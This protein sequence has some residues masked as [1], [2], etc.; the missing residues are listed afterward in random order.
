MRK[1]KK[2]N[3]KPSAWWAV[4]FTLMLTAFTGYVL[5][6]AFVIPQT[7]EVVAG[8]DSETTAAASASDERTDTDSNEVVITDTTYDDG[9]ISI[10]IITYR[11][12]DT[13]VYVA[14]ITLTSADD[15][16]TAFANNTYGKN[17]TEN[18]SV[19]AA[20]NN[21]I[22]AINGDYY[23]ARS[24]YVI[25]NGTLYRA[26]SSDSM[27]E[28]LVIY[29]DGTMQIITEGD[30]TAAQL[31]ADGAV[32]VF[33]FGPGLVEN[34]KISVT[35]S[36]EVD[37]AMT[38]NPR[39]AIGMI[40]GLHYVMV[41]ADG[42]TSES[43]GLSLY[44]LAEFMQSELGVTLAYNLDG[45]GSSTMYFNG[46]VINNPTTNGTTIQERSVSDIVYIQ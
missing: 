8:T 10:T 24:G 16:L 17:I 36:E 31:L 6:E 3:K 2:R 27:Q 12:D 28:D 46:T 30:I 39:T 7:Y 13:A 4:L 26:T 33:S 14:D 35:Q 40:D 18:T 29:E 37:K 32:Q 41:V 20:A 19:I 21:A 22:L 11:V 43:T 15:L 25:R 23:S 5:L 42:R 34:G 44:E 38:S 9:S 45:G 1:N